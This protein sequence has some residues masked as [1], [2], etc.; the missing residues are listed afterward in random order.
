VPDQEVPVL[1]VGGSLVGLSTALMLGHHG[2]RSLVVEH[3]RGTAIHPR[4]AQVVQRTME[5]FRI[6]GIE[7][8][9]R[10]RSDEQ[11]VQDGAIMAVETLAGREIAY[12][13]ANLNEGVRDVSPTVRVFISQTM[14]EPLLKSR[15]EELG[16]ELRFATEM[17]SFTQHA[18]G[19]TATLT[20]RDSVAS[21]GASDGAVETVR[22]RYMVAAD[23]AR[24]RVRQALGIPMEGRGT[25]SKS[26]TIYFRAEVEPLLR[27]RNLSV[28]YVNNSTQRGFIRVEKPFDRGFLAITG[29]GDPANP[30]TDVAASLDDAR[31]IELV[32][33][34]LGVEDLPV[35]IDDIMRWDAEA[36]TAA[37]FHHG[38]VFLA[39]DAAH[40]MPPH[41]GFGGNTGVQ[42]AHNLAWKLAMALNGEAGQALLDSYDVER[43]PVGR[44]TAEQAYSRYVTRTAPYLAAKGMQPVAPDLDVELGYGYNSAVIIPDGAPAPLH[45][46]PRES[47]GMPGTRAPHAW[48]ELN[49]ERLSTID[50]FGRNFVLLVGTAGE[51]WHDAARAVSSSTRLHLDVERLG[52]RLLDTSGTVAEAFGIT[53]EG[54]SLIRPDGFVAW[55]SPAAGPAPEC[56]AILARALAT[57]TGQERLPA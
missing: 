57:A 24:S 39:G 10:Q 40:V 12:F 42:D 9:V 35:R 33:N 41:G 49:G 36:D 48:V 37:R 5:V 6:V 16:A 50:L 52:T 27:G 31:A 17:T 38:R 23:G 43:R 11:F 22:A 25:F 51:A 19:V 4:A 32:R 13:I 45:Q 28:I 8:V 54:A 44:M 47:H 34:A 53:A 14:L 55:R 3:H 46:S 18:D 30:I 1:I 21:D 15:A 7:Q 56:A 26:A 20:H 29:L 2:I